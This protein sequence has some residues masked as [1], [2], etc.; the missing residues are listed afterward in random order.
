MAKTFDEYMSARESVKD[1]GDGLGIEPFSHM[2]TEGEFTAGLTAVDLNGKGFPPGIVLHR[3]GDT[4]YVQTQTHHTLITGQTGSGKTWTVNAGT[5]DYWSLTGNP[6]VVADPKG[7]YLANFGRRFEERGY[8]VR[9]IYL[10]DPSLGDR[11]N[12]LAEI[13]SKIRSGDPKSVEEGE[14][15]LSSVLYSMVVDGNPSTDSYWYTAPWQFLTGLV[16]ELARRTGGNTEITVP[17]LRLAADMVVSNKDSLK[18]FRE[19]LED[20][21]PN[22]AEMLSMLSIDADVTRS[23]MT[24]YIHKGLSFCKS[25]GMQDLLSGN[26][27]D[28]HEL[29]M[30][31]PVAVFVV[32]PDSSDIYDAL[33]SI[34]LGQSIRV[35]YD[36]ADR[37]HGGHL[38]R[39]VL[40]LLD[41]F[42]N[43]PRIPAFERLITTARSRRIRFAISVQSIAQIY[44][45]YQGSA[46]TIIDNCADWICTSGDPAFAGRLAM[47]LGP[48]AAGH[49]VVTQNT[50]RCLPRGRPLV[51]A[52]RGNPFIASL[53]MTEGGDRYTPGTREPLPAAKAD[54]RQVLFDPDG[55]EP[56]EIG[57][58]MKLVDMDDDRDWC[59]DQDFF[60]EKLRKLADSF[61]MG[62][63]TIDDED[64]LRMAVLVRWIG[65]GS[66]E[67]QEVRVES[68]MRFGRNLGADI[69]FDG[70]MDIVAVLN[71]G[72]AESSVAVILE[73]PGMNKGGL[74]REEITSIVEA[75][76][77][78]LPFLSD[79]DDED[80]DW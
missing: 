29:A 54:L 63:A 36:D 1:P 46:D 50:L 68:L 7:E 79:D 6:V 69:D 30:G 75:L 48:N 24:G 52:G 41:E 74:P 37:I 22:L 12:P 8:E 58:I 53:P 14:L 15:E 34:I 77:R 70:L 13:V 31:K 62:S 18:E 43:F 59:R 9:T 35:L 33:V 3:T 64:T 51:L 56:V 5:L 2:A 27:V 28:F 17:M 61:G 44:K 19:T 47:K 10:R 32:S 45:T 78:D 23:G 25:R 4:A 60:R 55:I 16:K 66:Y 38:P 20:D 72:S 71:G 67:G 76:R 40:F 26:D 21:N 39:E 42:A 73:T 57:G 11:V 80:G 65:D 49:D